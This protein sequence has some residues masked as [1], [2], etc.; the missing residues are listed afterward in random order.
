MP[1]TQL[2]TL[3]DS[4]IS[5][6][7]LRSATRKL[8]VDGHYA[9]AVEEAYKC[10]NNTVKGK[11]R[12]SRDGQD[13]MHHVFSEEDPL[14]KLNALRTV[15]ERDEQAG[16]RFI[17]AGCMTGVRNPRAHQHNLRDD[18]Q[19]A[20]ELLVWANHLMRV[21]AQAK[22]VRRRQKVKMP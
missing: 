13:L 16:Y 21:V 10:V 4:L 20:L 5:S 18:P 6:E 19:A 14:L 15:S 12:S 3:Y 11:S 7:P 17:F 2:V 22:R 1:S 8:F 9:E